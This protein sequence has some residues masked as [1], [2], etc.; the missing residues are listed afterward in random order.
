M[1]ISHNSYKNPDKKGANVLSM[2]NPPEDDTLAT[3]RIHS[4]ELTFA[5]VTHLDVHKTPNVAEW[6]Q[7]KISM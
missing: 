1:K 2:L 4:K 6:F 7:P 3:K 5:T